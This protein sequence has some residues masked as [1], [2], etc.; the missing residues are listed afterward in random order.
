MAPSFTAAGSVLSRT[1]SANMRVRD[2][3]TVEV[4]RR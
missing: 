4:R 2:S 1:A 3:S